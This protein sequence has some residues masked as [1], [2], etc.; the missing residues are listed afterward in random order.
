MPAAWHWDTSGTDVAGR[1]YSLTARWL[2]V[3]NVAFSV[4]TLPT[5]SAADRAHLDKLTTALGASP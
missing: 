3:E 2:V 5:P 1:S 4:V